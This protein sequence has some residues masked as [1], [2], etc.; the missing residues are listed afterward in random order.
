MRDGQDGRAHGQGTFWVFFLFFFVRGPGIILACATSTSYFVYWQ[1]ASI[2]LRRSR[3]YTHAAKLDWSV[4]GNPTC[5]ICIPSRP[6]IVG[7]RGVYGHTTMVVHGMSTPPRTPPPPAARPTH[8]C[9]SSARCRKSSPGEAPPKRRHL[10]SKT[11]RPPPFSRGAWRRKK[12]KGEKLK[13]R[14]KRGE[15]KRQRQRCICLFCL[16]GGAPNWF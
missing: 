4:G 11:R 5:C 10:H 14:R 15:G 12:N 16:R 7:V 9:Q 6:G 8:R 1:A 3:Q 13:R 2:L